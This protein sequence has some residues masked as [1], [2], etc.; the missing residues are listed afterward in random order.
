MGIKV[1]IPASAIIYIQL[2]DTPEL[3]KLNISHQ[4]NKKENRWRLKR[5]NA[6][7]ILGRNKQNTIHHEF[8]LHS[9]LVSVFRG[10]EKLVAERNYPSFRRIFVSTLQRIYVFTSS[11][12]QVSHVEH[13]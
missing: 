13:K 11:G 1:L 4:D 3:E 2:K 9:L 10:E 12:S 5:T 8:K 6:P 7:L